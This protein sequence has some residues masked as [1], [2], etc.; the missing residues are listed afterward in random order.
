MKKKNINKE[1]I[2]RMLNAKYGTGKLPLGKPVVTMDNRFTKVVDTDV[3]HTIR[4]N[5]FL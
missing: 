2:K 4:D 3:E 1:D 5:L